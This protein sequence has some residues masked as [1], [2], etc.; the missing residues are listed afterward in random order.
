MDATTK[1]NETRNERMI[2]KSLR[3][4]IVLFISALGGCGGIPEVIVDAARESAKEAV[5]ESV[6]GMVEDFAEE[7]LDADQLPSLLVEDEEE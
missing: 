6:Q 2:K 5:E 1:R 4:G 7:I 3:Y